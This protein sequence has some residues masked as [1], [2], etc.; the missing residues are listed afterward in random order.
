L[1][2]TSTLAQARGDY[3]KKFAGKHEHRPFKGGIGHNLPQEAPPAFAEVVIDM[4]KS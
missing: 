4:A 3:A 1:L 2:G